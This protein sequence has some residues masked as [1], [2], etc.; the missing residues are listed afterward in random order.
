MLWPTAAIAVALVAA[1]VAV[2][3]LY[4]VFARAAAELTDPAAY[5]AA[6]EAGRAGP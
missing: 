5:L 1:G 3:P 4:A 2:A 6:W